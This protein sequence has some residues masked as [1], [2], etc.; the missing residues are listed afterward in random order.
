MAKKVRNRVGFQFKYAPAR[1]IH[2]AAVSTAEQATDERDSIQEQLRRLRENSAANGWQVVDEL[3]VP[4]HSREFYNYR[5]FVEDAARKGIHEPKR[6]YEHWDAHTFDILAAI[7]FT[8]IGREEGITHEVVARTYDMGGYVYTQRNGLIAPENRRMVTMIEAYSS[9]SEVDEIQ[10]RY[11]F[12]M[13][14]RLNLGKFSG[15]L[16]PH[17]HQV[18]YDDKGKLELQAGADGTPFYLIINR[19]K[20]AELDALYH[21][22]VVQHM[23]ASRIDIPMAELGFRAANGEPH[24]DGFYTQ[25][26]WKTAFHGHL[27]LG[28][29]APHLSYR[30]R[31][32][33][34]SAYAS[35]M[36][37]SVHMAYDVV[38]PAYG[39]ERLREFQYALLSGKTFKGRSQ[40]F[41][42]NM[43]TGL[44]RCAECGGGLSYSYHTGA[45]KTQQYY[46]CNV[47]YAASGYNHCTNRKSARQDAIQRFVAAFVEDFLEA[48][49]ASALY[50]SRALPPNP[51]DAL[52]K[53][54]DTLEQELEATE[55]FIGQSSNMSQATNT[56]MTNKLNRLNDQLAKAKA[57][58][59]AASVAYAQTETDSSDLLK[60]EFLARLRQ[61]W[62]LPPTEINHILRRLLGNWRF[63]VKDGKPYSWDIVED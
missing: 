13:I 49:Q 16:V 46:R 47:A 61:L 32:M 33:L 30:A 51:K 34:N 28:A 54:I 62:D 6:L 63:T 52:A 9:K 27:S 12:G 24:Y 60:P 56:R 5:D 1:V 19:Q 57:E 39:P 59:Q 11:R 41:R 48:P 4:G 43:F 22:I 3:I 31:W 42:L 37:D 55:K 58:Y 50:L 10:R 40:P 15:K 18:K 25:E 17:F 7:N 53:H 8:R 36:P 35:E 21:L 20:Q 44:G 45:P 2:F 14:N 26:V 29:R 38:E 23:A